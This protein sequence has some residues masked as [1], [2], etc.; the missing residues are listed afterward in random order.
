MADLCFIP[1]IR[2][3]EKKRPRIA[4]I[5]MDAFSRLCYTSILKSTKSSE[6]ARHL[7][8][9]EEFYQGTF[10]KFTSDRGNLIY[11]HFTNWQNVTKYDYFLSGAEFKKDF[12][13]ALKKSNTRRFEVRQSIFPKISLIERVIR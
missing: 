5:F 9:A 1:N 13:T 4:L 8:P 3:P 12:V 2:D 10:K 11:H 6:I 7:K